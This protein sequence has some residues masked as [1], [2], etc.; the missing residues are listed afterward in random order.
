M[1]RDDNL[2]LDASFGTVDSLKK[3]FTRMKSCPFFTRKGDLVKGSRWFSIFDV[4]DEYLPWWWSM[5]LMLV[6]QVMRRQLVS[7]MP[8]LEACIAQSTLAVKQAADAM[9]SPEMQETDLRAMKHGE[10]GPRK[11]I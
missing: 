10:P 7:G 8:E 11:S 1:C 6:H 3:Y 2:V 9:N 5:T 4:L